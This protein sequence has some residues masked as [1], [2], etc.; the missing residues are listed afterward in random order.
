MYIVRRCTLEE[1]ALIKARKKA[2]GNIGYCFNPC[3]FRAFL[4]LKDFQKINST[5]LLLRVPLMEKQKDPEEGFDLTVDCTNYGLDLAYLKVKLSLS[6]T[7]H[8]EI[9]EYQLKTKDLLPK[10]ASAITFTK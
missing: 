1:D 5:E 2:K 7:L 3:V 4:E 6:Q 10:Y 8:P 9:N